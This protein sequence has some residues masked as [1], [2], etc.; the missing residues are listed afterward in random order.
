[1]SKNDLQQMLD[2]AVH[3]GH[4]SHRWNPNMKNYIHSTNQ[5]IHIIDLNKTVEML[6][7]A[8]DFLAQQ[9]K[10][11]K[12]VLFVG[13]KQHVAGLVKDAAE[14]TSMPY[15]T[16]RWIPGLLTNFNTVKQRI[17]YLLELEE[18]ESTGEFEKYTKKEISALKKEMEKLESGLGGM[19]KL[20]KKPDLLLVMS[21]TRDKIA[22]DEANRLKIPVVAICD[23]DSDPSKVDYPVP[24]NDDSIK[25]VQYFLDIF[26]KNIESSAKK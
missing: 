16:S 22:I 18:K 13:T 10:E 15:V 2:S 8:T 3:Y 26:T 20:K 17:K 11:G 1:M 19:K 24:G 23:T 7:K 25:S 4:R 6:A 5:G 14:K 9:T 12:T 21:A